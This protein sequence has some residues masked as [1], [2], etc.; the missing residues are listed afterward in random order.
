MFEAIILGIVQGLTEF[1]PV[2]STAHLIILPWFFNWTGEVNTLTFDIAL[3]AGTLFA[4]IFYF[5]KEWIEIIIKKRKLL[6]LIII[7]SF[8]AGIAGVLLNNIV[9]NTLRNPLIICIS[10]VSIGIVM[11]RSEKK[12]QHKKLDETGSC[13]HPRCFTF[14]YNYIS[15]TIQGP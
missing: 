8:P 3:H 14:R 11:M 9:E 7:A 6:G 2:S 15:R 4:L 10:L 1:F 13:S 12:P 5:W